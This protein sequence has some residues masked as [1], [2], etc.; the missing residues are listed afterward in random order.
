MINET[1]LQ[2]GILR[3]SV[4]QQLFNYLTENQSVISDE[5]GENAIIYGIDCIQIKDNNL[6]NAVICLSPIS[7]DELTF[8]I[9]EKSKII[10][11]D[12]D[13]IA[14]I[15]FKASFPN[16]EYFTSYFNSNDFCE[17]LI[18]RESYIFYFNNKLHSQLLAKGLLASSNS[19]LNQQNA[20]MDINLDKFNDNFNNELEDDELKYFA[21]HLGINYNILKTEMDVDKNNSVTMN[22]MKA[23]IKKRLSGE[24]FRPIFE[25]YATLQNRY[26]EKCMG[27]IDLQKFFKEVQK[28]EISYL[29]ACQIVIE[30]NSLENYDKKRKVIENFEDILVKNKTV[31]TQEIESI[32][33]VQNTEKNETIKA[34]D[35]L[36]LYLTLYE[37]NMMLH[38]LY[39]TVYDREKL[40][41]NLDLDR[42][43][44]EYYI[45]SSHNTYITK[46]QLAGESSAKM[47]STSLLYNFRLV[48]LDCYNGEDDN[49]IITHGFTLVT[50]LNLEDILY[51]L[52][53]TAFINSDLPVILSIENHLDE[54]HQIAMVNKLKSILG[55]LYIFPYDVKPKYVPTLREMQ[56]KFL[57]KC[58]GKKLWENEYIP[59][60]PYNLNINNTLNNNNLYLRQNQNQNNQLGQFRDSFG[61]SRTFTGKKI[62]FLS[63]KTFNYNVTNQNKNTR[64]TL[65]KSTISNIDRT[66]TTEYKMTSALEN[67]RGL[68][69]VKY[70]KDKIKTNYYKPWEMITIKCSKALK[71]SED[72]VEKLDTINLT[73][74]CLIKVYPESFDS[75]NYNIIK[76]FSC[77]C[78][79]CAL[80]IQAT[81]DDFILYDKIFFKQYQGLGYVQKPEK[82]LSKNYKYYDRPSYICHM[83]IISLKNCSKLIEDE[84]IKIDNN[85]ELSLK[86]YSIG[87]KED[88]NNTPLDCKLMNGVIFPHFQG[89]Y[90][91]INYKVYDF[92]LSAIMIKI[93]YKEKMIGRCCIP[94]TIMKLGFRRIPIYDN[95]CFNNENAYMVGFFNLQKI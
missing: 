75:S 35:H 12:I 23:Y 74:Q 87:I 81:E 58:S 1:K 62:I 72:F 9:K 68:L 6:Y 80:N 21:S 47:Y 50:N 93:K 73:Q 83:E 49:I 34:S 86:I 45:K 44:N 61:P 41:T 59:K 32:L 79:A 10:R 20:N 84:K 88:E 38:S 19:I 57:I 33:A 15:N 39:L 2:N 67:V 60:K 54:R 37:F 90:P 76:C 31:N 16:S 85:G 17:I 30:F 56:K 25:K 64:N 82:L 13:N 53:E 40:K 52:K 14:S 29:E 4:S 11:N 5:D 3:N 18:D 63:K 46:H 89:Q 7:D 94:Y 66:K 28:E 42:P 48:E 26:K 91:T 78:Q 22:E 24:Q 70:N 92:D 55:D 43:I 69:G 65:M 51:E 27:P 77:G 36:R 95:E 8:I 71:F